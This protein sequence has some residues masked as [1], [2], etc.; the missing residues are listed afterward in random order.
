MLQAAPFSD[1]TE[2]G[3]VERGL[4]SAIERGLVSSIERGLVSAAGG[5]FLFFGRNSR[6][7]VAPVFHVSWRNTSTSALA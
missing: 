4:V 1:A 2:R 3:L 6:C 5:S 7:L